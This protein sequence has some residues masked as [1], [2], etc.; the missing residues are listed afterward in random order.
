MNAPRPFAIEAGGETLAADRI[1]PAPGAGASCLLLHGAG[2]SH[3]A[4]WLPLRQALAARGVGSVAIDFSGHGESS[5]RTPNSLAKR[6]REAEAALAHLDGA[7]P[8]AVIGISMSGEIAVRLAAD[9]RHRIGRLLTLVGAAYHPDAFALPFGPA[10]TAVLRTPESWRASHAFAHIARFPGR[11][12]LVRAADDAVIPPGVADTLAAR[13]A[14][15]ERVEVIDLPGTGHRLGEAWRAQPGF[16][17]A[18]TRIVA[19]AVG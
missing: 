11:V 6:Q 15:A 5:A 14:A 16:A 2:T 10:F 4:R 3:R 9:P 19:R 13:A 1:V 18:L 8:R 17:A 12:T 7:G